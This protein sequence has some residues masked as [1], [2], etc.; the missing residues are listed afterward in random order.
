MPTFVNSGEYQAL[1]EE[2][3]TYEIPHPSSPSL[4]NESISCANNDFFYLSII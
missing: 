1:E 3:T 2:I 4:P